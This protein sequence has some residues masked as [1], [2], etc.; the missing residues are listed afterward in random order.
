MHVLIRL[1]GHSN[2]A[3]AS[4]RVPSKHTCTWWIGSD[5]GARDMR[6]L[7]FKYQ[8]VTRQVVISNHCNKAKL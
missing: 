2:N 5:S 3:A 6:A 7:D 8:R 1:P 4:D